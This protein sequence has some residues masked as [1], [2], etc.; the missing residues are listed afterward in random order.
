MTHYYRAACG[1]QIDDEYVVTGGYD[2]TSE[3]KALKRVISYNKTG[4]SKTLAD[5]SVARFSHA[6]GKFVNDERVNV[7]IKLTNP[8]TNL[9]INGPINQLTD[10][11]AYRVACTRLK[12]TLNV[13]VCS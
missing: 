11:A 9:P 13:Y 6:C 3:G 12:S 5:L 8:S 1:I 2:D 7:S 10:K 4:Y